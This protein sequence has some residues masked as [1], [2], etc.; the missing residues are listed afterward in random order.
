MTCMIWLDTSPNLLCIRKRFCINESFRIWTILLCYHPCF[1]CNLPGS[2]DPAPCILHHT[3]GI[4]FWDKLCWATCGRSQ[5]DV[6]CSQMWVFVKEPLGY[7]LRV[8]RQNNHNDTPGKGHTLSC[9]GSRK[10]I[11]QPLLALVLSRTTSI[12]FG[13]FMLALL[14]QN[15]QLQIRSS[16][17]ISQ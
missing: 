3:S 6:R 14:S 4:H 2:G 15:S 16:P 17:W 12:L 8:A 7:E 10:H 1:T 9:N 11:G 13:N 5:L